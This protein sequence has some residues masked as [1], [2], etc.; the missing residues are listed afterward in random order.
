MPRKSLCTC[1]R[2]IDR[3][4]GTHTKIK[5]VEV[6]WIGS[7]SGASTK[8]IHGLAVDYKEVVATA[9][10]DVEFIGITQ[11]DEL[12]GIYFEENYHS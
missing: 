12:H 10:S 11:L 7:T 5:D 3:A 1:K 9:S 8:K 4:S 2:I 6:A